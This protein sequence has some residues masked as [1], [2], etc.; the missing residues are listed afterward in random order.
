V[1]TFGSMNLSR[2]K[3]LRCLAGA[4]GAA[5][6]GALAGCGVTPTPQVIEK[7]VE[8]T[9]EVEKQVEVTV[10]VEKETVVTQVVEKVITPTAPAS[11]GPVVLTYY[12]YV[13]ATNMAGFNEWIAPFQEEHPDIIVSLIP[14]LGSDI[15]SKQKLL[16]MMIAGTPPDTLF[17]I[18]ADFIW[19]H[20][21]QSLT[22]LIERD[23]YDTSGISASILAGATYKDEVYLI[24]ML[25]GGNNTMLCYNKTM[26][27]DV[28]V[29]SL[30]T[31]W[32][33]PEWTWDEWVSQLK[34]CVRDLDGDGKMDTWGMAHTGW[35]MSWSR[36]WATSWIDAEDMTTITCDSTAM[37][38]CY[39]HLA[40]LRCSDGVLPPAGT[41]LGPVDAFMG[42]KVAMSRMGWWTFAAFDACEVDWEFVPYP[43]APGGNARCEMVPDTGGAIVKGSK[44]VD[45]AW[46]FI[47]WQDNGNFHRYR[48]APP[49]RK[50][51][52]EDWGQS[53][54]QKH[55]DV[56]YMMLLEAL[57]NA[58][59]QD[60]VCYHP[61]WAE[62]YGKVVSP[63]WQTV[64]KCELEVTQMLTEAQTEMQAISDACQ[65]KAF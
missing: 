49:A 41:D 31:K 27:A 52:V 5:L 45:A 48:N 19:S 21:V 10:E 17:F 56:N 34:K 51:Y 37:V 2:R 20:V 18:P 63:K 8:V 9:R 44:N 53:T 7:Q 65:Q 15:E 54:F 28:G 58:G 42:G 43:T 59:D 1:S 29:E 39:S 33:D 16:S 13:D 14:A 6:V 12:A 38:D 30:P 60:K 26:F 50:A 61:C 40:A 22:P 46:E 57:E 11:T 62:M 55:P 47:K 4:T 36:M 35:L 23:S 3:A 32:N 24:P 25:A 64:D